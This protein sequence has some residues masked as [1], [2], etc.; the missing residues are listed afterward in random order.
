MS[1]FE[2]LK[3]I[4]WEN[5]IL[6]E[7]QKEKVFYAIRGAVR[8]K[9]KGASDENLFG[10]YVKELLAKQELSNAFS[11]DYPKA[12]QIERVP[13][14]PKLLA[15]YLPQ[16]YP[17]PH[18]DLWWGKGSTEWTN[19]SKAAA[20]YVGQYQ[21][22]YPGELGFY[23]LRLSE[24]IYRQIELASY[25]GIYGFSFYYYWFDGERLL[26]LPFEK[27]VN[28]ENI[29][30][31]FN[32]CWV[33]ESWT[34]QWEGT[35]NTPLMVQT[36]SVESYKNFIKSCAH[37]FVRKNYIKIEGRPLLSV[38]R[39]LDMPEPQEVTE[40]WRQYVKEETGLDLYIM[41]CVRIDT[42]KDYEADYRALGFDA[43]GEFAPGPQLAL[44]KDISKEKKY[45][46]DAFYG[47]VYDYKDFVE[48]KK[49]FLLKR[50]GI[51]RACSPMWDNTARKKN[52]GV[53]LDG[54]T[55][56]LYRQWL[57]DIIRET[58]GNK[59]I[60]DKIVFIN[61][62]NE[63]AEGAY[64]EPDLKWKYAYLEAT[65]D[66]I[67]DARKAAEMKPEG[68]TKMTNGGGMRD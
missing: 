43:C 66:A 4:Y 7:E 29:T 16:Y 40:Y 9:T 52:K 67:L 37:L 17:D 50:D 20:Q 3:N 27:F 45:V 1:L 59:T 8:G 38:Y 39:P 26:D 54:A 24:N 28:D 11:I 49:Y 53:I 23:D 22:R 30:F 13:G 19:V 61:A 55:P 51:Y 10:A 48:G 34:K 64:L 41:G 63:W 12:P 58:K 25:F 32:I 65:R 60:D 2:W 36:S 68:K 5:H 6:T 47:K 33:N 21:P 44:M 57:A 18:N 15:Y 46:C 14:D 56:D 35:S 42:K 31:P 62:W